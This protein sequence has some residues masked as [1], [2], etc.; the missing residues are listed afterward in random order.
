MAA[1]L[2]FTRY[3]WAPKGASYKPPAKGIPI[4]TRPARATA[5]L[6]KPDRCDYSLMGIY[7][8]FSSSVP[9][10]IT[11]RA[12]SRHQAQNHKILGTTVRGAAHSTNQSWQKWWMLERLFMLFS[13]TREIIAGKKTDLTLSFA[14]GCKTRSAIQ[15]SFYNCFLNI[16]YI[17]YRMMWKKGRKINFLCVFRGYV[18]LKRYTMKTKVSV[19][20]LRLL[21]RKWEF[22]ESNVPSHFSDPFSEE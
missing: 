19:H 20:R 4:F 21:Y 22:R 2:W 12:T 16:P 7:R 14:S 11:I 9:T 1:L 10:G 5:G 13:I 17:I 18:D 15:S 8:L 6:Q 3:F